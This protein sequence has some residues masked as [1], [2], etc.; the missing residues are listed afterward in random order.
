MEY[1][2]SPEKIKEFRSI[3]I[4][5]LENDSTKYEFDGKLFYLTDKNPVY[6]N[7]GEMITDTKRRQMPNDEKNKPGCLICPN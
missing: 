4:E 1:A 5:E 7:Q 6:N 2:F 3:H